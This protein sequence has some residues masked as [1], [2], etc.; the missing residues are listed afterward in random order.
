MK[1]LSNEN[2]GTPELV[3]LSCGKRERRGNNEAHVKMRDCE[4]TNT[5]FT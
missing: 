2:N 1:G 3:R 4:E 5:E